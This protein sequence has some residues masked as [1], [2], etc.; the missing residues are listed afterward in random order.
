MKKQPVYLDY[1][2]TTPVAESVA[3]AMSQCLTLEGNFGNPASRSHRFGWQAEEAVENARLEVADF[4][5]ANNR[6]I[7]WTSGATEANNLAL[8]GVLQ[9]FNSGHIITSSIEHK[10][11]LDTCAFLEGQGY[12]V[13]YLKPNARGE[14]SVEQ[15]EQALQDDTRLVSLMLVNNE[16]GSIN[17]I[18]EIA[19]AL[20]GHPCLLHSDAA[21]AVAKMNI[22]VEQL[23][24]DLMSLSAH[25]MY[26]P[27][28]IGV[29]YV[30]KA[31]EIKLQAQIH[32]GGHEQG[33]RSGTLAT[34]QIVGFAKACQYVTT[35][36]AAQIEKMQGLKTQLWQGLEVLGGVTL[37]GDLETSSCAHLNV[38]FAGVD[39]EVL[40]ASMAKLAVSSGSACNSASVE[41][42]YVLQ[43]IGVPRELAHAGVR[44][45]LG[46]ATSEQ[47]I[48]FAISELTRILQLLRSV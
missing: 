20:K 13:T 35:H 30:R 7:I 31:L 19:Q 2:A 46:F 44:F 47:D 29:L 32:G 14:V 10:A 36:M 17:P 39:G 12:Q 8:K 1:A 3:E 26:G 41:P 16:L 21:Q 22:D 24:V 40:L 42:S 11:I 37:N 25:K 43:A 33:M 38:C 28:G 5:S 34:H 6:E 48:E 23:G 9:N 15:V 18:A 27:K 4:I 45:S